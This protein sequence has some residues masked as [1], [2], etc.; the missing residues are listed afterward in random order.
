MSRSIAISCREPN[1]GIDLRI[2]V[3]PPYHLFGTQGASV[4]FWGLPRIAE[5]GIERLAQLGVSDPVF[6]Y[7][8]E[9]MPLLEREI[10]LLR[11]HLAS[12]D[13]PVDAKAQWLSHLTYCYHLLVE[14]APKDSTPC[15]TIG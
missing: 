12:I 14:T 2:D 13:F 5:I 4:R 1:T 11:E 3:L 8:W 9:E 6:F 10:G 7:G 15:L